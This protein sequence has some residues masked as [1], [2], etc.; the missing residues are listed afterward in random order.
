M[1]WTTGYGF[2]VHLFSG[3]S[4][5][6][7]AA[8]FA[9][10]FL[11][12]ALAGCSSDEPATSADPDHR[13]TYA[14]TVR[15]GDPTPGKRPARKPSS[16]PEV[17]TSAAPSDGATQSASPGST[18]PAPSSASSPTRSGATIPTTT[19]SVSDAR[20]DVRSSSITRPP[21]YA[22][23][24]GAR[25]T[26]SA[27]GFELRVSADAAFPA[28]QPDPD[29]TEN[30]IFY[31]DVDGDGH[32]DYEVWASLADNGWGTSYFDDP[33]GDAYYGANSGVT[34]GVVGGDL[35]VHFTLDHLA[36]A[37]RFRWSVQAEWGSYTEVS[38]GT[39]SLDAAP[40]AGA[41]QF[42]G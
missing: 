26:R 40:S 2:A 16:A 35:V 17:T 32:V 38:T 12:S 42:P 39:T 20:N 33:N 15:P 29:H 6:P 28:R 9:G 18:T 22:D 31:A 21:A 41:T 4:R 14:A 1:V 37:A 30:V 13:P 19:A 23:L 25:L 7:A 24:T 10:L 34:A 11:A 8:A 27:T 3:R 36:G 5:P